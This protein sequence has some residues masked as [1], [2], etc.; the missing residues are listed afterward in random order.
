MSYEAVP[1]VARLRRV[2][3]SQGNPFQKLRV[4][5]ERSR[6]PFEYIGRHLFVATKLYCQVL[7]EAPPPLMLGRFV[8]R[9]TGVR[10]CRP[11]LQTY[12]L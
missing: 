10:S 4:L 8:I 5:A 12:P 11:I 3:L 9:R 1:L 2:T 6:S 7:S